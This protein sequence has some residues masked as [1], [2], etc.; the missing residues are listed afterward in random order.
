MYAFACALCLYIRISYFMRNSTIDFPP[1]P[2]SHAIHALHGQHNRRHILILY[3]LKEITGCWSEHTENTAL[4]LFPFPIHLLGNKFWATPNKQQIVFISLSTLFSHTFIYSF[5]VHT[6]T[7]KI[8]TIYRWKYNNM[9]ENKTIKCVQC[10]CAVWC[11]YQLYTVAHSTIVFSL[12]CRTI[13]I[14]VLCTNIKIQCGNF[15]VAIENTTI[16]SVL[17]ARAHRI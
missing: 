8:V 10:V 16:S 3:G 11:R 12:S 15:H 9:I 2:Q 6:S 13:F 4:V 5:F 7:I 1:I 14:H 17:S